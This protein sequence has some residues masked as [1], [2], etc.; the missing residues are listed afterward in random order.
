MMKELMKRHGEPSVVYVACD[1]PRSDIWRLSLDP[2]YKA[3]RVT[4]KISKEGNE[5]WGEVFKHAN[6]VLSSTVS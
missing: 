3:N 2:T 6:E 4:T 5:V 1:C